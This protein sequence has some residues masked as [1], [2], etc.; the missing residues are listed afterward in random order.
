MYRNV[1]LTQKIYLALPKPLSAIT[2][3]TTK[4]KFKMHQLRDYQLKLVDNIRA[5]LRTDKRII[6]VSP[7]GSGKTLTFTSMAIEA[8]NRGHNVLI[9]T[10]RREI[11]RQ[12]VKKFYELGQIVGQI[13]SGVPM[14]PSYPIQV[15]MIGTLPNRLHLIKRPSMIIIDEAHHTVSSSW[16]KVIEYWGDVPT[17]GFTATP[18]RLDGKGLGTDGLFTKIV[19]GPSIRWLVKNGYLSIPIVYRHPNEI[20]T[21]FKIK[22]GDYDTKEQEIVFSRGTVLGDVLEHYKKHLN[23]KP[24]VAFCSTVDHSKLVAEMFN[25][26]GFRAVAVYGDMPDKER[27]AAISGLSDGRVQIITSCDVI[28]EG[29]DVPGI[30]GCILLRRTLSLSLFLQQCGRALRLAPGKTHAIILDHAGNYKIHGSVLSER[31]WSLEGRKR[32]KK[33]EPKMTECP[34]CYAIWEGT[35]QKCVSCGYDFPKIELPKK[36]NKFQMIAGELVAEFPDLDNDLLIKTAEILAGNVENK[37]NALWSMAHQ[38]APQGEEGRVKL[39][40]VRKAMGYNANWTNIV[41]K[42]VKKND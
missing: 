23:G 15:G 18:I 40:A 3:N 28:S 7:T 2:T 31:E 5:A 21:N 32:E 1:T 12:T 19:E 24:T 38:L 35:V 13:A 9:T 4:L 34:V 29:M 11:Q 42:K 27:D 41:W 10:H 14:M 36:E 8:A 17:I 22:G 25:Q 37:N 16:R 39:D 20:Q 26:A 6:G 33:P 30:V